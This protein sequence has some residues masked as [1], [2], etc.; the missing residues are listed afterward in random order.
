MTCSLTRVLSEDTC[1]PVVEIAALHFFFFK[2]VRGSPADA[3]KLTANTETPVYLRPGGD[4]SQAAGTMLKCVQSVCAVLVIPFSDSVGTSKRWAALTA[5]T[6]PPRK[7]S[8][9]TTSP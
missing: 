5:R 9:R 6:A 2:L 4:F 7:Q 8:G 1:W 3:L